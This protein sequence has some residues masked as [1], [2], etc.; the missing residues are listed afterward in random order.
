MALGY[1]SDSSAAS[2]QVRF[3]PSIRSAMLEASTFF[4][5]AGAFG[6]TVDIDLLDLPYETVPRVGLRFSTQ[7]LN[8]GFLGGRRADNVFG[9]LQ[10]AF[11]RGS[12][13]TGNTRSDIFIG[14]VSNNSTS[15][16]LNERVTFGADIRWMFFRP[17]SSLFMRI[18]GNRSGM[19]VL[20]GISLGYVN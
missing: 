2:S 13:Q 16:K 19:T 6:V 15:I 11:L 5:F 1:Q 14:I 20:F 7:E 9:E 12:H 3:D 17:L 4:I 8:R 10:G 18:I